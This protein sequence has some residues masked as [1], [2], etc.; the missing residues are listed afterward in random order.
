[1]KLQPD[2]TEKEGNRMICRRDVR[3]SLTCGNDAPKS[4]RGTCFGD[5]RNAFC[6]LRHCPGASRTAR[7][8]SLGCCLVISLQL[9]LQIVVPQCT[10]RRSDPL[11]AV[12][13]MSLASRS[14]SRPRH[15]RLRRS[16]GLRV[17]CRIWSR[18]LLRSGHPC[19]GASVVSSPVRARLRL[20]RGRCPGP[21]QSDG[22]GTQGRPVPM[23]PPFETWL[24]RTHR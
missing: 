12:R 13:G 10:S 21:P 5:S 19:V 16:R 15:R 23:H 24:S 18:I 3:K 14:A 1:M 4:C 7:I 22:S 17:V 9:R 11:S 8:G 20:L 2:S 6:C